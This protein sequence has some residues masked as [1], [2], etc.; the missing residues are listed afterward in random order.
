MKPL[1]GITCNYDYH[2]DVGRVSKMG[3]D[4]QDWNFIAGDYINA[5]EK[6]GGCP[7][8]IPLCSNFEDLKDILDR[9]DGI[10]IS[11]GH[12]VGP[13]NYGERARGCG[14]IMPMRDA[15]DLAITRYIVE[16]TEKPLLGICRG[17]QILNVAMGGT[18]Y[19]D[20]EKDG[21]FGHHFGDIYPRNYA[22]HSVTLTKGSI[23]ESIYGKKVIDVNSFHHQAVFKPGKNIS[24]TA[25]SSDGVSEGIEIAEKKFVV[26]VQWHPEMM[27]DSEEQLKIFRAFVDNCK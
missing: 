9:M 15:Q 5:I 19:Q 10:M 16:N 21:S 3:I 27:Y 12:D 11:G 23:L 20:L 4:G 17:I 13:E 8:V 26:A 1:I 22:W 14:A 2:D 18:L 7:V 24:V 6:V 25:V